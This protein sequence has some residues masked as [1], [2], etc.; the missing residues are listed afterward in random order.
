MDIATKEK[1]AHHEIYMVDSDRVGNLLSKKSSMELG[2]VEIHGKIFNISAKEEPPIG[3]LKGVQVELKINAAV[4]PVQQPCRRLPI[5]LQKQV[6]EKL[7]DLLRQDIIEPAP[8]YISWASPLVVTPK[9]SGRSV[10]LCVDMRRANNAIMP[11]RHPLPTFDEIMPY[12]EGYAEK[13]CKECIECQLVAPC[14]KPEPLRIEE[15]L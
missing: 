1:T 9:T 2:I 12:L 10:R 14:D 15:L 11:E 6:E 7:E 3:K 4:N 13:C 5:P 8:L